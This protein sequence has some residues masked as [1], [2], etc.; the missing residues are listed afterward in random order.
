MRLQHSPCARNIWVRMR[1]RGACRRCGA[2]SAHRWRLGR[3]RHLRRSSQQVGLRSGRP[4]P[5]TGPR[6]P[7]RAM[8]R[9]YRQRRRCS[10]RG[11]RRAS[12]PSAAGGRPEGQEGQAAAA[13]LLRPAAVLRR[14]KQTWASR[15]DV[16]L[17]LVNEWFARFPRRSLHRAVAFVL[18]VRL[19]TMAT[20]Q[21][22]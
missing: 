12:A 1:Q 15:P 13:V 14:C 19:Q 10:C 11:S 16:P 7:P 4:G 8:G 2:L 5:F 18:R 9:S 21:Y 22:R 6:G 20:S 3:S 17:L